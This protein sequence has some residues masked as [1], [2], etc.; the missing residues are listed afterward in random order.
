MSTITYG[1]D[2]VPIPKE[3]L[4]CDNLIS[5]ADD[6]VI[7]F[8]INHAPKQYNLEYVDENKSTLTVKDLEDNQASSQQVK[9]GD[10]IKTMTPRDEK[11]GYDF[12][13]WHVLDKNGSELIDPKSGKPIDFET[14]KANWETLATAA[15]SSNEIK[16]KAVYTPKKYIIKYNTKSST[17]I[18]DQ[19]VHIGM[20]EGL[21]LE[22]PI[23]KKYLKTAKSTDRTQTPVYTTKWKYGANGLF[24]ENNKPT[25]EKLM[26]SAV[27]DEDGNNLIILEAVYK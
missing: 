18:G 15:N 8:M 12:K 3:G 13:C 21:Q 19:P 1:R 4:N 20:D 14:A 23:A 7:T 27:V 25:W 9:F 24:N 26:Q 5:Q 17:S 2:N 11:L 6:N 16:L 22:K 10:D